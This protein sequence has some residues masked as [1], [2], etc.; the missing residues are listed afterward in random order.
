MIL[1]GLAVGCLEGGIWQFFIWFCSSD[2]PIDRMIDY[3]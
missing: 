3:L 2:T 1:E